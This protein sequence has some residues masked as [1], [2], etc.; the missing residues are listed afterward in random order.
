MGT[1]ATKLEYTMGDPVKDY[2]GII[3][4]LS[5]AGGIFDFSNTQAEMCFT[6]VNDA[7]EKG[8]SQPTKEEVAG[9]SQFWWDG[10]SDAW[11][12]AAQFDAS[13]NQ[14]NDKH[15]F[16]VGGN[17]YRIMKR[18]AFGDN[19]EQHVVLGRSK[20]K[21]WKTGCVMAHSDYTVCVAVY[22]EDEKQKDGAVQLAMTQLMQAY[23]SGGY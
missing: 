16:M 13:R 18:I 17:E 22:D 6:W 23:K 5:V 7:G 15:L 1:E 3:A 2:A 21:E 11:T 19:D 20:N 8:G 10:T 14:F 9:W 12:S 4:P